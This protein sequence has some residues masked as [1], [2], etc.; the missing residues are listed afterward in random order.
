MAAATVDEYLS[1]LPS[2]VR[3]RM[4]SLRT[5]VHRGI[6]GAEERI[7]LRLPHDRP[8]PTALLE[9]VVGALLARWAA[10]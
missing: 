10:G 4:E 5:L 8:L 1:G 6:P 3:E 9:V 2:D 7:S